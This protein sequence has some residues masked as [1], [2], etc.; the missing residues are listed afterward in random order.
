M[1]TMIKFQG[2]LSLLCRL[3][4]PWE[5]LCPYAF[6]STSDFDMYTV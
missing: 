4:K 5:Q 6:P 3:W 2:N 1:V